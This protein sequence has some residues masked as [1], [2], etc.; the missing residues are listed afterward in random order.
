MWFITF[1]Y[2]ELFQIFDEDAHYKKGTDA[3]TKQSFPCEDASISLQKTCNN[4]LSEWVDGDVVSFRRPVIQL[5][6]TKL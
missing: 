1:W 4:L 3:N 2:V 6:K 5:V